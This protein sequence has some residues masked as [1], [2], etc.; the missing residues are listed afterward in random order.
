MPPQKRQ[1][2]ANVS[3]AD[4]VVRTAK[5]VPRSS[6]AAKNSSSLKKPIVNGSAARP[7]VAAPL[8]RASSGIGLRMPPTRESRSSP[9]ASVTAPAVRNRALLARAC[10]ITYNEAPTAPYLPPSPYRQTT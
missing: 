3:A 8:A 5:T 2:Y 7:A 9:V 10:E 1:M 4:R 6:A